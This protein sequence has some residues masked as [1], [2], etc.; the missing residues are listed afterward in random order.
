MRRVFVLSLLV[1]FFLEAGTV[2]FAG[3]TM[4]TVTYDG[5]ESVT[6]AEFAAK[7]GSRH[8]WVAA[9]KKGVLVY[10]G[11]TYVFTAANRTVVIDNQ[12]GIHLPEPI[13]WDGVNL[14]IPVGMLE[15]IFSVTPSQLKP[16]EDIKI[17]KI[18]L[19]GSDPTTIQIL[20]SGG[21]ACD[22][23][24]RSG[25]NVVLKVEAGS[26]VSQITPSGLVSSADIKNQNKK[27]TI[28]LKLSKEVKV[29]SKGIPNGIEV[30]F[31]STGTEAAVTQPAA[32]KKLVIVIDPGHGGKDPGAIG[33]KG[34]HEKAMALDTSLRL[35]KLLEAQGHTV[36]MTRTTDKYVPLADRTKYANAK[37]AD[38][39][40]SIHY[41][42][43]RSSSPH[44]FETYFLG[45]HRLEYAKNVALRENASLKYDIGENAY[46]PDAVLND[47]IATLLTNRFQR[48]SEELAGY[49]QDASAAKTGFAN[50][51][52]N[53]AGFYVLK[54]CSMPA[55]LVEGGFLSNPGEEAKIRQSAYRQKVAEGIAQ[56]VAKYIKTL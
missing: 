56:G 37:K 17:E 44:G 9:K 29:T 19:S 13:G 43:N 49:I 35:K 8:A 36:Y 20:A 12:A 38:L 11:H 27:T 24:E 25:T 30:T 18:I 31:A 10:A 2:T 26:N 51:G 47:I 3:K 32:K 15:R 14:Y 7:T 50:R 45:M 54:G 42:A 16:S 28:D 4:N 53:Q 23:V 22:V 5:R 55:V 48:E 40:I 1:L 33:K 21:I 34:T 41:N 39:F 52:L 6:L 46:D